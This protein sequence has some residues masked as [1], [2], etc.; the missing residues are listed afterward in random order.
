MSTHTVTLHS[1][2]LKKIDYVQCADGQYR[3]CLFMISALIIWLHILYD[4]LNRVSL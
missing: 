1:L 2:L 3:G 4:N